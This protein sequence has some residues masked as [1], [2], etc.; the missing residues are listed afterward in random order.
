MSDAH[1][2][3]SARP[4]SHIAA[5]LPALLLM[6]LIFVLSSGTQ[7]TFFIPPITH[8]DKV[9]HALAFAVLS[10]LWS[11][12][13]WSFTRSLFWGAWIGW[14]VASLYGISDEYHQLFVPGRM[15]DVG[16]FI[17]DTCGAMIGA[18]A[19]WRWA[20]LTKERSSPS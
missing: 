14:F 4:T 18:W 19:W 10:L 2:G 8:I 7:A 1:S 17:A 3:L 12:V 16:D 15:G 13:G 6:I 11:R 5:F 20:A 9:Q